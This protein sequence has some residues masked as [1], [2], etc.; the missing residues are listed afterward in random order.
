MVKII[1]IL[2]G[3]APINS[4][5]ATPAETETA[6]AE[7]NGPYTTN[8]DQDYVVNFN[9]SGSKGK[10]WRWILATIKN[11]IC[12]NHKFLIVIKLY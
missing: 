2:T 3:L 12:L 10:W 9:A 5:L 7:A 6:Y 1:F 8:V 11:G 4:G